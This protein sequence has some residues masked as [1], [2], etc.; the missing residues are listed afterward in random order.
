MN[1]IRENKMVYAVA[2]AGVGTLAGAKLGEKAAKSFIQNNLVTADEYVRTR[3]IDNMDAVHTLKQSK[4][5]KAFQK[6]AEKASADYTSVT[7]RFTKNTKAGAA[8]IGAL[9]LAGV[10]IA[11]ASKNAKKSAKN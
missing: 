11:I 7:N 10:G 5:A 6:I 4:W 1:S 2:G 3:I 8:L 9:A